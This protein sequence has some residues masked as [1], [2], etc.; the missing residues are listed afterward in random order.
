MMQ[1]FLP[2]VK[3][4]LAP[5]SQSAAAT[6]SA[7]IDTLGADHCEIM[8]ACGVEANTSAGTVAIV[9]SE[10]D[11]TDA[12]SFATWSSSFSRSEDVVAAHNVRFLIDTKARKRYLKLQV[13][14][15]T[16]TTNDLFTCAAVSILSRREQ[17]PVGTAGMVGS[18]NDVVVIG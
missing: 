8:V 3:V 16:H 1:P 7:N 15:G 13:T 2:K 11:V 12:T 5:A 18:T 9:V 14:N 10:A 4:E 17:N 6:R